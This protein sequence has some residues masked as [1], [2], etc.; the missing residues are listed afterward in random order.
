[1]NASVRYHRLG[2]TAAGISD[3]VEQEIREGRLRP[4]DTLPTVRNLAGELGIS[5]G[6][7]AAAYRTLRLRGMTLGDGRRGTRIAQGPPS[8]RGWSTATP[9]PVVPPGVR[10]LA[11]GNP[12]PALLPDLRPHL[13]RLAADG[14]ATGRLYGEPA[15]LPELAALAR[16]QF[17]TDGIPAQAL[18]VMDG[19]L[20]GIERVLQAYLRPGDAVAVEDPGYPGVLDLVG[21]L[22]FDARAVAVD[23][24]GLDPASLD[25]ALA[26]GARAVVVTPRAHNPTGAALTEARA[27]QL[28]AVLGRHVDVVVIEDDHAGLVAGAPCITLADRRRPHWA[29]V[30]SVSKSLGPDL[31]LAVLAADDTTVARVEGRRQLG[32]G[33]VSHMLQQLVV[34]LWS[35][36]D[37][38]AG[39][40]RAAETYRDRRLALIEALAGHGLAGHGTSGLNVWVP[41]PEEQPVVARLLAAGWAVTAGERFRRR[42]GPAIRVTAATLTQDEA[43]AVAAE[44]ASAVVAAG[45]TRLG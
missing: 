14:P 3:S 26:A 2:R 37:V 21:A 11:T 34:A 16:A 39:C 42:S 4:G 9:L 24:A 29:V 35:D 33:W 27:D 25:K 41:V 30:R 20:D 23:D 38:I 45:A 1:M 28:R 44:I 36:D 17:V 6:T 10:D 40:R 32:A 13:R 31:R 43:A 8:P 22:G 18:A 12:D 15:Q 7:V 5:P 19:A